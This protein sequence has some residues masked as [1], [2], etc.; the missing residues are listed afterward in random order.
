MYYLNEHVANLMR[1]FDQNSR[2]EYIR[3]DLNENPG[4]LPEEFIGR[5]LDKV[6]PRFLSQYLETVPFTK[7]LAGYLGVDIDQICL[8]N[9]SAEAIRHIIEAYSTQIGRAS[10]RERV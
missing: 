8:T 5:V 3:M 2:Q 4:G 9:G 1:I 7:T 10:C 6:D